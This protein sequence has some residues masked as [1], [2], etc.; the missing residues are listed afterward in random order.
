M[1][2]L[3]TGGTGFIGSYVLKF[4]LEEG[5]EV[6]AL[7]RTPS[8]LAESYHPRLNIFTGDITDTKS[9]EQAIGGCNVVIHLA[10]LVRSAAHNSSEFVR[11]N[12]EGTSFLLQAATRN[13]I[14]KFVFAS[15]LSAH[16][17]PNELVVDEQSMI[18]PRRFFSTYAETKA[19][20]EE[21]VLAYSRAGLPCI[22]VYPARVFGKGPLT[23]ANGATKAIALYL[24]NRLPFLIDGG[25][26]YSSWAYVEDVA[27]G[28]V[29]AAIS[30]I[31][32]KRFILGG[33][34]RTLADVYDIADDASHTK[35][36]RITITMRTALKL[37]SM[38]EFQAS[39]SRRKPIITRE[40]L[41][42][43]LESRNIS[44]AKAV[45]ELHYSITPITQALEKTIN[46]LKTL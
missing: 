17:F 26:Q 43:I 8:M 23:D 39:F 13:K 38:L 34:N 45:A 1:R 37:V 10:A 19:K 36:L 15:S 35:H 2:V 46:W 6:N 40:W 11:V 3:L 5:F 42:F 41:Q 9:I 31:S 18:S 14:Q 30:N 22:I 33:E 16:E 25:T 20:A 29:S 21:L 12:F 27:R 24:K 32:N 28:I 4:L 7:T 44:S